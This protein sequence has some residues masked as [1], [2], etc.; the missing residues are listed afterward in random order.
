MVRLHNLRALPFWFVALPDNE[1]ANPVVTA[2]RDHAA[3]RL[4]H[5]SGRPWLIGCWDERSLATGG[6][7][8][9]RI[10][11][12]GQHAVTTDELARAATK[13][14]AISDLDRLAGSL[15]GS[16]HLVA[17]VA[18]Q[19]RVQGTVTATRRVFYAGVDGA[20]VAADRA[21]VLAWLLDAGLDEGRLALH[22]LEPHVLYPLAGQPV[23]QGVEQLPAD[24]Y[25]VLDRDGHRTVR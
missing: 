11:V 20:T 9:T 14:R 24:H 16:S 21:D 4:N 2:L 8:D 1:A 3:Q 25:L 5:G 19:V 15:V 10:A 6:A 12:I 7:G 22:L 23:W 17:S 18:G 13:V